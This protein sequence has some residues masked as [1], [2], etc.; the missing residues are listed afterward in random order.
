MRPLGTRVG[1]DLTY[2][3]TP[4]YPKIS[5]ALRGRKLIFSKKQQT[6][7]VW[8]WRHKELS[9]GSLS[10]DHRVP[11]WTVSLFSKPSSNPS[12]VYPLFY[13]VFANPLLPLLRWQRKKT[14]ELKNV[15]TCTQVFKEY[16]FIRVEVKCKVYVWFI[17][18]ERACERI[19]IFMAA[20][21][22]N[23]LTAVENGGGIYGTKKI[24]VT[25]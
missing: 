11:W 25:P 18:L 14:W 1:K 7:S 21:D 13:R 6:A 19:V 22:L 15:D 24:E 3:L 12:W 23:T 4:S 10:V 20:F 2:R 17:V 8:K 9:F 16:I 5:V